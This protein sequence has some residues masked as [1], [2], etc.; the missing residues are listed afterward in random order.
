MGLFSVIKAGIGAIKSGTSLGETITKNKTKR[1]LAREG[2]ETQKENNASKEFL[3]AMDA[4]KAQYMAVNRT[5]IESFVGAFNSLIR[6][7]ITVLIILPVVLH[8][9][10]FNVLQRVVVL[11]QLPE[12]YISLTVQIVLAYFGLREI[13]KTVSTIASK[14]KTM[15]PEQFEDFK[16]IVSEKANE[17]EKKQ[18]EIKK[19]KE[20]QA[21]IL[22]SF[23]DENNDGLD[24]R[25]MD[26]LKKH[27]GFRSTI[28]RCTSGKLTIGYG[29][30]L[31][32]TGMTEKEAGYLLSNK[33]RE[34]KMKLFEKLTW[35]PEKLNL[36]RQWVLINMAFNLGVPGLLLWKNT[37]SLIKAGDYKKASKMMLRSKWAKQVGRRSK[38]LSHQMESG[39]WK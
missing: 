23:I 20:R 22:N 14:V 15:K 11:S 10:G 35:I 37:L 36:P 24:D 19:E 7:L 18:D 3:S 31:E 16:K 33:V 6:P 2:D 1:I 38:E 28:Y 25:G 26:Q 9:L 27:E 13:G 5:S 4:M 34:Y 30:N 21:E 39:E 32:D 17:I 8:C 29:F 12:W